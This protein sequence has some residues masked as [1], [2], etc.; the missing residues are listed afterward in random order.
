M[1]AIEI[2]PGDATEQLAQVREL[3][4]EYAQSLSFHICF[5]G[6]Q[7]ELASLPGEYSPPTGR[8]FLAMNDGQAAGCVAL[9]RLTDA[10]GELKRLYVRPSCRG[11][12]LGRGLALRVIDE[13]RQ[14][15]YAR[16][17]LDTLPGMVEARTLYASLGFK[18][19]QGAWG[20]GSDAPLLMELHL[21]GGDSPT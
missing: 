14:I 8:L 20:G 5:E 12:G 21:R 7:R 2:L 3:F 13:A 17:Q 6:F 1:T 16:L 4:L 10:T 15:G 11:R 9:R 19:L 18:L